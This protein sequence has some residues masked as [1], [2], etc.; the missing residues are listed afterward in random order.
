MP[1]D[2]AP[3]LLVALALSSAAT[4][5]VR[6]RH[7]AFAA[8]PATR[9]MAPQPDADGDLA[10]PEALPAL[11]ALRLGNGRQALLCTAPGDNLALDAARM[12]IP[13]GWRRAWDDDRLNPLRGAPTR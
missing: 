6:P 5:E 8:T 2:L 12:R 7:P 4:A 9:I 11:T 1:R 10:C 13:Q 3:F